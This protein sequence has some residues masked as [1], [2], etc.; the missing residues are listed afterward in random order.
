MLSLAYGQSPDKISSIQKRGM[1]A[2]IQP[3]KASTHLFDC[4]HA[5]AKVAIQKGRD[6]EFATTGWFDMARTFWRA[7]V[8][9]VQPGYRVARWRILGF[10]DYRVYRPIRAE[11]HNAISFWVCYVVAEDSGSDSRG[12]D[13]GKP[14][15]SG[16]FRAGSEGPHN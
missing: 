13:T 10:L 6:L 3:C 16:A 4:E 14:N 1:R 5:I 7:T 11:L 2:G 9:K 8:K 12:A 15:G